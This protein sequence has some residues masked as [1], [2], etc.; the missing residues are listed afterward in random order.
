MSES[1]NRH[2]PN[3]SENNIIIDEH[4]KNDFYEKFLNS[5][6]NFET[7]RED[8]LNF[9][10]KIISKVHKKSK[11]IHKKVEKFFLKFGK[12][13]ELK[14]KICDHLSQDL[15]CEVPI[16]KSVLKSKIHAI[17][18]GIRKFICFVEKMAAKKELKSKLLMYC[19]KIIQKCNQLLKTYVCFLSDFEDNNPFGIESEDQTDMAVFSSLIDP[20]QID[21]IGK[22]EEQAPV[23]RSN[24]IR[25][26]SF[27]RFTTQAHR[28]SG[29][30]SHM[31]EDEHQN[32]L[33]L[34]ENKK[35][36]FKE[37]LN[38]IQSEIFCMLGNFEKNVKNNKIEFLKMNSTGKFTHKQKTADETLKNMV[39]SSKRDLQDGLESLSFHNHDAVR[40][41]E[42]LSACR[43][44]RQ[45]RNYK[46]RKFNNNRTGF[47]KFSMEVKKGKY[48]KS[49]SNISVSPVF[50]DNDLTDDEYSDFT[51]KW[52]NQIE[53]TKISTKNEGLEKFDLEKK[54][55]FIPVPI[56]QD[57]IS[58]MSFKKIKNNI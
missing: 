24:V 58:K 36:I 40:K 32:K 6:Q 26:P 44:Q 39:K 27:L 3:K 34:I 23:K 54:E 57:V 55:W 13:E 2:S 41:L 1:P 16:D 5:V 38:L 49:A 31:N 52:S 10:T 48:E 33:D 17:Y 46:T 42:I 45:W 56:S 28:H 30:G 9:Q 19:L 43:I 11:K 21:E 22:D 53:N 47:S 18:L 20:S 25:L 29:R 50:F 7:L 37:K 4:Q 14:I 8:F 15:F 12:Y 35:H 51:Q